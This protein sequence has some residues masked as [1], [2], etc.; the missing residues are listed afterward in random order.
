MRGGRSGA[1]RGIRPPSLV[2]EISLT[3]SA[4]PPESLV[5]RV[6]GLNLARQYLQIP[7]GASRGR[8]GEEGD[9]GGGGWRIRVCRPKQVRGASDSGVGRPPRGHAACPHS[10][11]NLEGFRG[12]M[13]SQE[14]MALPGGEQEAWHLGPGTGLQRQVVAEGTPRPQAQAR[15]A[16]SPR[17]PCR[18]WRVSSMRRQWSCSRRPRAP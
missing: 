16:P 18:A 15:L 8:A 5:P 12:R 11:G 13:T 10:R 17:P 2:L 7:H 4:C 6:L 1:P 3:F 14:L 9:A